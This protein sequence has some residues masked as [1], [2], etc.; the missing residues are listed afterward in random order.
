FRKYFS[1]LFVGT[2]T[3]TH[4]DI[5]LPKPI[6]KRKSL[7]RHRFP[8]IIWKNISEIAGLGALVEPIRLEQL[9]RDH[10]GID[11]DPA[12]HLRVAQRARDQCQNGKYRDKKHP[13]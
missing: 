12:Q 13:A 2:S 10:A 11:I 3:S 9:R 8:R 7:L 1:R 5:H 4:D 6:R